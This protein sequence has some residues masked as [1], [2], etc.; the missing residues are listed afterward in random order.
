VNPRRRAGQSLVEFALLL[1]I[2]LVILLG[3]FDF[4]RAIY[5]YNAVSNAAREGGRTA[6]VNQ[7]DQHVRQRA[8]QQATALGVPD[9]GAGCPTNGQPTTAAAGVCVALRSPT[10]LATACPSPATIGCVAV[11]SVKWTFTAITPVIG[12][13]IGPIPISA[14]TQQ[15]IESVCSASTCPTQ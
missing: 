8:A 7:Y 14:T 13:I 2:L 6:I 3:I 5:A 12:N 11:V 1:P 4:G 15:A 10:N 9:D